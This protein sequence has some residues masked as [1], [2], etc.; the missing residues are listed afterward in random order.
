MFATMLA[1][2]IRNTR[3]ETQ[4]LGR[5]ILYFLSGG[6]QFT[7]NFENGEHKP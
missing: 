4:H 1:P 6:Q 5:L 7:A 2:T 3:K